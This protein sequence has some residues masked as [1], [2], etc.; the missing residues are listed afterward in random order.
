MNGYEATANIRAGESDYWKTIPVI[1]MTANVFQEDE[2]R[3]AECGMSDYVTK[4]IDMNVIY[5]VLEKWLRGQKDDVSQ[6]LPELFIYSGSRPEEA[7]GGAGIWMR[8]R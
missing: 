1:A 6:Y 7:S 2:S 3:A 8:E 4:P 5:S